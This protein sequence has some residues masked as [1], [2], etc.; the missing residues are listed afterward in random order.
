VIGISSAML[1]DVSEANDGLLIFTL[2]CSFYYMETCYLS[3][4]LL[5]GNRCYSA[6]YHYYAALRRTNRGSSS[7]S[8][9][10]RKMNCVRAVYLFGPTHFV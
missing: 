1:V 4:T 10:K 5:Q 3:L 9:G 8:I 2:P 7:N 6:F